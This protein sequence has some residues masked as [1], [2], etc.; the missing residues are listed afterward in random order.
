MAEFTITFNANG[1]LGSMDPITVN[2]PPSGN[3]ASI[4][5]TRDGYHIDSNK[6][7]NT[8]ADGSGTDYENKTSLSNIAAPQFGDSLVLYAKWVANN[9]TITATVDDK[10]GS[11][12]VKQGGQTIASISSGE[13]D[14]ISVGFG[15]CSVTY[16]SVTEGYSGFW[17]LSKDG[18]VTRSGYGDITFE[19]GDDGSILSF[20]GKKCTVTFDSAGG[21]STPQPITVQGNT[22]IGNLP[23]V[24]REGYLFIGWYMEEEW[25]YS[26]IT[27]STKIKEDVTAIAR[28]M[29]GLPE[30]SSESEELAYFYPNGNVTSKSQIAQG[31]NFQYNTDGTAYVCRFCKTNSQ[32]SEYDNSTVSGN[33]IVPYFSK[34]E[35]GGEEKT[36]VIVAIGQDE[37]ET[38][39][40]EFDNHILTGV[41]TPTT[42]K[43][44]L[45]NGLYHC[46][47]IERL[48]LGYVED[49]GYRGIVLDGGNFNR[50]SLPRLLHVDKGISNLDSL[51]SVSL[52]LLESASDSLFADCASLSSID[53]PSLKT[54]GANAIENCVSLEAVAFPDL[55]S[56]GDGLCAAVSSLT[57]LTLPS[58]T[59]GTI[60]EWRD[61]GGEG[62]V[63]YPNLNRVKLPLSK[64]IGS[65]SFGKAS[66]LT[67][68]CLQSAMEIGDNTFN[69]CTSLTAVSLPNVTSIG[70]N[71]FEGCAPEGTD[72]KIKLYLWQSDVSVTHKIDGEG[73][74]GF[75]DGQISAICLRSDMKLKGDDGNYVESPAASI[76]LGGVSIP[77]EWYDETT[78]PTYNVSFSSDFVESAAGLQTSVTVKY[79]YDMP[80]MTFVNVPTRTGYTFGG[81]YSDPDGLGV[82]YYNS[83]GT[84]ARKW[85]VAEDATLYAKWIPNTYTISFEPG[86]P[87]ARVPASKTVTYGEPYGDLPTLKAIGDGSDFSRDGYSF[88]GWIL[89]INGM[90]TVVDSEFPVTVTEDTTLYANWVATPY[91]LT[92]NEDGGGGG[93]TTV[94]AHYGEYLPSIDVPTKTG[95]TFGGY[96]L[97][98]VQWYSAVGMGTKTW[99][100]LY[101]TTLNA[102]WTANTYTVTLDAQGGG[103][104]TAIATVTYGNVM[105][106]SGIEMPTRTGYTFGGYWSEKDGSG[107]QYYDAVGGSVSAWDVPSDA[108]LYAKWTAATTTVTLDDGD[109]AEVKP[110]VTAT[111]GAAMPRITIPTKKGNSFVGYFTEDNGS[112]TQY[113]LSNGE[114]ARTWGETGEQYTLHA[115]WVAIDYKVT[116]SAGYEGQTNT[117]LSY[118][119]DEEEAQ[120]KEFV[121][122]T[123]DKY[124]IVPDGWI[125]TP[126]G[127]GEFEEGN[128]PSIEV[129]NADYFITIPA[130]TA[131]DF[132]A[133]PTWEGEVSYTV[134]FDK[135]NDAAT[136]SM[137]MQQI[138]YGSYDTLSRNKFS[139]KGYKFSRW[140]TEAQGEGLSFS[141]GAD[142]SWMDVQEVSGKRNVTLYA[143]WRK[144]ESHTDEKSDVAASTIRFNPTA[145]VTLA[146]MPNQIFSRTYEGVK[147]TFHLRTFNGMMYADIAIDDEDVAIGV[148]CVGG[149]WLVPQHAA[150]AAG[151]GNFKFETLGD[152]YPWYEDFGETCKLEYYNHEAYL[153]A[154][155]Q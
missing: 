28:W 102:K 35:E 108:T 110:K 100:I 140:C 14:S 90:R 1:G 10:I 48:D 8:E 5:F 55:D 95:Y 92:L 36:Y 106:M 62:S 25:G 116:I 109:K 69:G 129:I 119:V 50:L 113:Y 145:D 11:V 29:A 132:L 94:T 135:N 4:A 59:G 73:Y 134:T 54:V 24:T 53:M 98:N 34:K 97:L 56:A 107:K 32:T 75:A 79:G 131:T 33:V 65:G 40:G 153:A 146:Q 121:A 151:G 18:S 78:S 74:N 43:K 67:G 39:Y 144:D 38:D 155:T 80:S 45:A 47:A 46:K 57:L 12:S 21:S 16:T 68:I 114:G 154:Q 86:V 84:S 31:M 51:I 22:E 72:G 20:T 49:V 128:P 123:R 143:I 27:P 7:W 117:T 104:G 130:G 13:S 83:D 103:D 125:L 87:G 61:D 149:A 118:T 2:D 137:D 147:Y 111:Y 30:G 19:D 148:R 64:E 152:A 99:D 91:T 42:V 88:G 52:P 112:G 23:A 63:G 133:V 142:G 44:V 58:F 150:D 96:F 127:G 124:K 17:T 66:S 60:L 6:T 82:Q 141:D 15:N 71:T 89:F 126:T 115:Y 37:E 139:L 81:L 77:I 105:P 70:A 136:G 76:T 85:D 101:D 122:P 93:T 26:L 41:T 9:Y 3:L 120:E 138:T